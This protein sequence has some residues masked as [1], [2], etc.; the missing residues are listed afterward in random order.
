[1][2]D[3]LVASKDKKKHQQA[4]HKLLDILEANDLFL[5]PEK[6]VWEQPRVDYLGLI[7][8]GGITRMDPAFNSNVT[9]NVLQI[10]Q[11][12][13]GVRGWPCLDPFLNLSF[14]VEG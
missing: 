6:C 4:T 1:M 14:W 8:E 10:V 7:L 3:V 2:D 9:L 12:V 5:K 11:L 13:D